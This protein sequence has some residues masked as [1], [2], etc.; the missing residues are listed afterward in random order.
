M[1]RL[2]GNPYLPGGCSDRLIDRY[3][4]EPAPEPDYEEDEDETLK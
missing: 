1:E 3:F 4:G 2:P